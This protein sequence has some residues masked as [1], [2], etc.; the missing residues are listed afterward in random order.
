MKRRSVV[1]LLLLLQGGATLVALAGCSSDGN[2]CSSTAD[3]GH[4]AT[5]AWTD[6][7]GCGTSGTCRSSDSLPGPTGIPL[8]PGCGCDGG[9]VPPFEWGFYLEPVTG[10]QSCLFVDAGRDDASA[11]VQDASVGST[12]G[13][14][15]VDGG[16]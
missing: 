16:K 15:D 13:P 1:H 3:C 5:C 2:P 12:D 14:E 7:Q 8:Y 9:V 11:P 6:K 4:G 10:S